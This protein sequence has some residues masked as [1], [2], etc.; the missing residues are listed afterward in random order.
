MEVFIPR[1]RAPAF[2]DRHWISS[3]PR[4]GGLNRCMVIDKQ[5]GSVL[6]NCVG[7][8]WGRMYELIGSAPKLSTGNA[9]EWFGAYEGYARGQVPAL[10]AVACWNGCTRFGASSYGHVAIVESIGPDY[11]MVSQSNYGGERFE[12]VKCMKNPAGTGYTSA[13]GNKLFQGFIYCPVAFQ[14]EGSPRPVSPYSSIDE[15]ARAIV[16]GTGPWYRCYGEARRKK[17]ESYGFDFDQVQKR[18]NEIM[19]GYK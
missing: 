14:A 17:V 19:R 12:Y 9:R 4:Y 6:P 7:Y 16:R 1:K 10:G 8:A 18:V 3:L 15:I 2:D 11:I 13:K 5:S